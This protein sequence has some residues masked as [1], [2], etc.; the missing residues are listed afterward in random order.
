MH[1]SLRSFD[2]DK[3]V[4]SEGMDTDAVPIEYNQNTLK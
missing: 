4:C 1:S 2:T 3:F